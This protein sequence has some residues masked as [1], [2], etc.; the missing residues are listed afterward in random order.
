[1]PGIQYHS[2]AIEGWTGITRNSAQ[3]NSWYKWVLMKDIKKKKKKKKMDK[4]M[5]MKNKNKGTPR[6]VSN[7]QNYKD[8]QVDPIYLHEI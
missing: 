4:E 1:M 3:N 5:E 6:S 7:I 2:A 8:L